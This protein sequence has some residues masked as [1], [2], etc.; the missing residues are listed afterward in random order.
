MFFTLVCFYSCGADKGENVPRLIVD[1]SQTVLNKNVGL[2][3]YN[4]SLFS[5][6]LESYYPNGNRALSCDYK[7]GIRHGD[8][9][10]WFQTGLL[11]F[12][13]VYDNGKLNGTTT[14]WWNNGNLRS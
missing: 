13:S 9:K 3:F 12:H 11:S 8:Y 5:G 6:T 4:D 7:S 14:S 10:K 2:V 1:E